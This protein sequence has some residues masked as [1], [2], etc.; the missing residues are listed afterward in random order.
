MDALGHILGQKV[1]CGLPVLKARD[2][3]ELACIIV[4]LINLMY[5][6]TASP[7]YFVCFLLLA[8]DIGG[9]KEQVFRRNLVGYSTNGSMSNGNNTDSRDGPLKYGFSLFDRDDLHLAVQDKL[10]TQRLG[11]LRA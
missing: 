10:L 7:E 6:E 2:R 5:R 3:F 4:C 9:Q 11:Y 1:E 8:P